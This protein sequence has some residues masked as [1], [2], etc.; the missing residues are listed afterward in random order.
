VDFLNKTTL[1]D[2]EFWGKSW[3]THLEAYLRATPRFGIYIDHLFK[4]AVKS[5]LEIACGS[6]RD[7]VY[8]AKK[9]KQVT[10]CDYEDKLIAI[11]KDHFRDIPNIRFK[12]DDAFHLTQEDKSVD[13]SFHNG[14]FI[15]F[16]EDDKI[17]RLLKEQE[18][19]TRKYIVFAVHNERNQRLQKSFRGRSEKDRLFD[20]RFFSPREVFRIIEQSRIKARRVRLAKFGG[21]V[22]V[23]YQKKIRRCPNPL[24]GM[25]SR[26]VP[27]LYSFLPWERTERVVAIIQLEP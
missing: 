19:V 21:P 14:F 13:L 26:L 27:T 20:V 22:D 23:L 17:F 11:I 7:S 8:L 4:K 2:Q 10:S 15:L 16:S 1:F 6:G 24:R 25:S 9:G 5:C 12:T 18:R 3:H